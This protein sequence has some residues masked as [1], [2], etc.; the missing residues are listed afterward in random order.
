MLGSVGQTVN[1]C[2]GMVV[3]RIAR[4]GVGFTPGEVYA[5]TL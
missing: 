3:D 1:G 5:S 2:G 4:S